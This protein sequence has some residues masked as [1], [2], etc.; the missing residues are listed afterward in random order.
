MQIVPI[1][2]ELETVDP[3]DSRIA[4][5]VDSVRA[6]RERIAALEAR[7]D[8]ARDELRRLLEMRGENWSDDEGYARL[9]PDSAR[10][11]Y[12]ARALDDLIVREPLHYGWLKEYR[13]S[14]V[15]R[16]TIQVK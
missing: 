7:N 12:D 1:T 4:E 5:L 8:A 10:I 16:G 2:Q 9:V 13:K 14:S 3:I 15:V 11:S 6:H